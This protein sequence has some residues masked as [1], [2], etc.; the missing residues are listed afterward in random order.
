METWYTERRYLRLVLQFYCKRM[1]I[2]FKMHLICTL[3][4]TIRGHLATC[5]ATMTVQN[6]VT[7]I[8]I[9]TLLPTSSLARL[10]GGS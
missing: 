2:N 1:I 7:I 9:V 3:M 4:E 6:K 10:Q 8:I 5:L